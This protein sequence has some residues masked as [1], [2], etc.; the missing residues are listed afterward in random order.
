MSE[1]ETRMLDDSLPFEERVIFMLN[2]LQNE[3]SGMRRQINTLDERVQILER[4][5]YDTKPMWERALAESIETRR[6]VDELR[7]IVED[8]RRVTEKGFIEFN[9][10]VDV[11]NS[12]LLDMRW[13]VRDLE[14]AHKTEDTRST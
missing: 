3:V 12:D 7:H 5:A 13:R 1:D 11:F 9:R 2:N 14:A 10:K 4:K 6:A 8:L